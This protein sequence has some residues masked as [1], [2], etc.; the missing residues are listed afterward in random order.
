MR[1]FS[2][3]KAFLTVRAVVGSIVFL[4][5][6][7][8]FPTWSR[9]LLPILLLLLAVTVSQLATVNVVR[10]GTRVG[11]APDGLLLSTCA[12]VVSPRAGV[13]V[14]TIGFIV[15]TGI[16]HGSLTAL[17]DSPSIAICD[18]AALS[19]ANFIGGWGHLTPL[20]IVGATIAFLVAEPATL[21]FVA[22]EKRLEGRVKLWSFMRTALAPTVAFWPALVSLGILVGVL[23]LTVPWALLLLLAPFAGAFVGAR[24]AGVSDIE[25]AH[26]DSLL[27]AAASTIEATSVETVIDTITQAASAIF[28]REKARVD[29]EAPHDGELSTV[30]QTSHFGT[31][32]FNVGARLLGA[33]VLPYTA[34]DQR[35]LNVLA[36]VAASALDKAADSE[37]ER[38]A[39]S[40]DALTQLAN[41]RAFNLQLRQ[42]ADGSRSPGEGVGVAFVDL[43]KFKEV[44]DKYGHGAGDEVLAE[45]SQRLLQEVRATDT[46]ARLGGDEFAI[47]LRGL[48]SR[49]KA[50]EIAE[51]LIQALRQPI[52]LSAGEAVRCGA[53]IGIAL[54]SRDVSGSDQLMQAAD[55]AMYQAKRAGR[56]GWVLAPLP[57]DG[58][59]ALVV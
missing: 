5:A 39:A 36:S 45:V 10:R 3:A 44:N 2:P 33:S 37:V 13:V 58:G 7:A 29:T 17:V 14:L 1:N 49:D 42:A 26:L 25:R 15:G 41:R 22:M 24:A 18:F 16:R 46:V 9:Q 40:R 51:R 11:F 32:Y 4:Y 54:S 8:D 56:D 50:A 59:V 12:L 27:S 20:S 34:R 53:S 43:D 30:L 52:Q 23:S 55:E 38:V 35:V 6:L 57:D 19:I 28:E 48:V 47:L 31:L 21:L